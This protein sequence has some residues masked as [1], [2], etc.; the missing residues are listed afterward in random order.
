MCLKT[1]TSLVRLRSFQYWSPTFSL[2]TSLLPHEPLQGLPHATIKSPITLCCCQTQA[3]VSK[4]KDALSYDRR[5]M[6]AIDCYEYE[7]KLLWFSSCNG[8]LTPLSPASYNPLGDDVQPANPPCRSL[9]A[10]RSSGVL[11]SSSLLPQCLLLSC[12]PSP[13]M[14]L[15]DNPSH[16]LKHLHF[17]LPTT[18]TQPVPSF[19][20]V[21]RLPYGMERIHTS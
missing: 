19:V 7:S 3:A 20:L 14:P 1:S 21:K 17:L 18:H 9:K 12:I 2:F 11:S 5:M 8:P 10:Y 13:K 16:P 15:N 4:C 6:D